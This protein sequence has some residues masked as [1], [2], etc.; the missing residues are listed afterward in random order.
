MQ[1]SSND[2]KTALA[3]E[4]RAAFE[5]A[6]E[7]LERLAALSCSG[8]AKV[9]C[10]DMHSVHDRVDLEFL[11]ALGAQ[12][13]IRAT[14]TEGGAGP[15]RFIKREGCSLPRWMRPYK[16]TWFFCEEALEALEALQED[17][18]GRAR[19]LRAGIERLRIARESFAQAV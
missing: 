17:E 19:G 12:K 1:K 10:R 14:P 2:T 13:P 4:L 7:H 18:P 9:C 15:C 8:C 3:Q 11:S 16:C 5:G 6:E